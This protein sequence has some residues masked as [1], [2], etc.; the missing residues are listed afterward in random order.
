MGKIN[1]NNQEEKELRK[2]LSNCQTWVRLINKQNG[3]TGAELLHIS[4]LT[5]AENKKE[6]LAL[7]DDQIRTLQNREKT[8][9][10][11]FL[12]QILSFF[13]PDSFDDLCKELINLRK[14]FKEQ[15]SMENSN[16]VCKN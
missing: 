14:E 6:F 1:T 4:N 3:F 7:L 10:P 2:L 5:K 12:K 11:A 16:H 13:I 9:S 15:V 8:P